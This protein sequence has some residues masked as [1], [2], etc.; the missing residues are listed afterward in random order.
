M[1][2]S[3]H[4]GG[5]R[6]R[7][8]ASTADPRRSTAEDSSGAAGPAQHQPQ[9]FLNL[10]VGALGIVYGDIGTSPLYAL[11]EC[12]AEPHEV[13]VTTAN[14]LGV[15]S[16]IFW[17][18]TITISVKYVAYVLRAD[19]QGEGGVLALMALAQDKVKSGKWAG[20]LVLFL[21]LFGAALLYGD[22]MI[23]PAISVLS[24]VEGLELVAP[25]L[26]PAVVPITMGI[27]VLLFLVQGRGTARVAAVFGPVMVM[28]FVV[29]AGL[30]LYQIVEHPSVFRALLPQYAFRFLVENGKS[31]FLTFGSVF[32]VVT[33]GEALYADMG[34]FGLRPIRM[35]WFAFVGPA[36]MLNYLGQGALLLEHP[37]A[38][39]QPFFEMA[40]RWALLP[41][42][43]LST[44][45]TI[46]ASQALISGAFSITRQAIMLGLLPRMTIRH[47][48]SH[49]I[50]Q[51][52]VP[53]V[54]WLLMISTLILV[55]AFGS[56]SQLAAAYGIAVT[57]TMLITT[58]LA[59]VVARRLWGWSNWR[60]VPI[61]A[62]L[63]AVDATFFAANVPKIIHG[64]WVPLVVGVA[65][66]MVMTTWRRGRKLIG[67][68]VLAELL[69]LSDFFEI[70]RI[71]RPARVPG[72]AV[73]MASN[74]NGVPSALLHN[75]RHNRVVH[76]QVILLTVRTENVPTVPD[77][78][79]LIRHDLPEGFVRMVAC[80]GFM[81]TPN[82]PELLAREAINN[83]PL[84]YTSFFLGRESLRTDRSE[85]MN[86]WSMQLFAFLS[87]NSSP[88]MSFFSVPADRVVELGGQ[89]EL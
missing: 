78:E 71:E 65:L 13:A 29:L 34:H 83:T 36:L 54:N 17:S 18:F 66:L 38:I 25:S 31:G 52:Y 51:I 4:T 89:I 67:D 28:W 47:T 3:P 84:D 49:Q 59:H 74:P 73:F 20:S 50:G 70:M 43:L 58:A 21:G 7:S 8:D 12:F 80:Y 27:L 11:R 53:A 37:Q 75:F 16:L 68:R 76:Q 88:A 57:T 86:R 85:E 44:L 24:A 61:T 30:G 62:V 14:I 23:T 64:G 87:R 39:S 63:L 33:G 5:P 60:A 41:L 42:L 79:R 46:I 2:S 81:E 10:C 19:N 22:G 82:I 26:S 35:T 48:S 55:A 1:E 77:D 15:L 40:P 6:P 69:P 45:A 56:S 9:K 32:L 72:T